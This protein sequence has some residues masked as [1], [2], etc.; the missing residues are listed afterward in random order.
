MELEAL[1]VTAVR[2]RHQALF[3]GKFDFTMISIN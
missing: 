3:I 1:V 2:Y